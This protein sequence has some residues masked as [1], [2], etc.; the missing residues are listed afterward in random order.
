VYKYS[1]IAK[2]FLNSAALY[3]SPVLVVKVDCR[4]QSFRDRTSI[5]QMMMM[6]VLSS[7]EHVHNGRFDD[8]T[9]GFMLGGQ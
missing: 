4:G 3:A 8:G 6:K 9:L 5:F 7:H 1:M 2:S